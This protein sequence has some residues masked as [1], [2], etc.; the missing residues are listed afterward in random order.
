MSEVR[1]TLV[2]E[3]SS[4]AV[5]VPM[6][7]WLWREHSDRLMEVTWADLRPARDRPSGL[8]EKVLLALDWYPCDLLFVHRDADRH[9]RA[10]R[11]A[12][13]RQAAPGTP[14]LSVVSVIPIRMQEAWLLFDEPMLRSAAGNPTGTMPLKLPS[15]AG[16]EKLPDPK[17][18]LHETL[19]KASGLTGRRLKSFSP[20][21]SAHRL[22]QL[23]A[24]FSPLRRLSAFKNL[25]LD[26]Q[27]ILKQRDWSR[28]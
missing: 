25:E 26:L 18:Q 1:A 23:I 3:G 14:V 4:D 15:L 12:E 21:V 11:L 6:L 24:D 22:G 27:D 17:R 9:P 5:L 8:A 20:R 7:A 2:T 19:A 28:G 10:Q 13:I 16:I